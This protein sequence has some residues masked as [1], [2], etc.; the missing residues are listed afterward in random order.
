[1]MGIGEKICWVLSEGKNIM[2]IEENVRGYLVRFDDEIKADREKI[3]S[4]TK[5]PSSNI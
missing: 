1:M 3:L 5:R 2:G 4:P